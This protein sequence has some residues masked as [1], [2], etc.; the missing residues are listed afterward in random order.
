MATRFRTFRTQADITRSQKI[1]QQRKTSASPLAKFRTE[2]AAYRAG[3]TQAQLAR[4][5]YGRDL[6]ER[7][8]HAR[9]QR[10]ATRDN[11]TFNYIVKVKL[12]E[13]ADGSPITKEITIKSDK[14]LSQKE[15]RSETSSFFD[16]QDRKAHYAGVDAF[17]VYSDIPENKQY[18]DILGEYRGAVSRYP[19]RTR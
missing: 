8:R 11:R 6:I 18:M 5:P 15:I 1:A 17:T 4:S 19:I 2:A 7:A 3:Y 12:G 14:R 10:Q 13:N 9:E 16:Y